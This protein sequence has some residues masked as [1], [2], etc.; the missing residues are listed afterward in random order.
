MV[1]VANAKAVAYSSGEAST[2]S[3]VHSIF[4]FFSE[5]RTLTWVCLTFLSVPLFFKHIFKISWNILKTLQNFEA[6]NFCDQV[7]KSVEEH[8]GLLRE[9]QCGAVLLLSGCWQCR[10]DFRRKP[11]TWQSC[12]ALL[13]FLKYSSVVWRMNLPVYIMLVFM[14][15]RSGMF[16]YIWALEAGPSLINWQL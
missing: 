9:Q 7:S 2:Y 12:N 4:I 13:V 3:W 10:I 11:Q 1:H 16:C 14:Q 15:N 5:T 6:T 8:F